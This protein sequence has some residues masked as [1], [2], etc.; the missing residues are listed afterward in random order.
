MKGFSEIVSKDGMRENLQHAI[1][2]N[3]Q[4]IATDT[5]CLAVIPVDSIADDLEGF[6]EGKAFHYDLLKELNKKVYKEFRFTEKTV[7]AFKKYGATEPD[8]ESLYS[9]TC[10]DGNREF[11]KIKKDGSI[12]EKDTFQYVDWE[13]VVPQN[14]DSEIENLIFNPSI[15]NRLSG[16]F[17]TDN[18]GVELRFTGLPDKPIKVTPIHKGQPDE[19]RGYGLIMPVIL[20]PE[21]K[22]EEV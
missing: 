10:V 12:D 6:S 5:Y 3:G 22:I 14:F 18:S 16:V 20:K 19:S 21:S 7:Q 2:K 8:F 13:T 17:N 11:A 4:I 15:L 1:V 9:A